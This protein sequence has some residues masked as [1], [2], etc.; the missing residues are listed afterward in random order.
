MHLRVPPS[1]KP[2]LARRALLLASSA[3]AL[4]WVAGCGQRQPAP[5]VSF[6]LLNGRPGRIADLRGQVVL[7]NFWATSCAVCVAEMPLLAATQR[8]YQARGLHTL[9]VAMRHDP[10]AA[11]ALFAESRALPFGVV[12]DNTGAV[13]RSFGDVRVTPT[14]VLLD[15][16]GQIAQ[17]WEGAPEPAT[18]QARIE[19]LLAET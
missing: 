8:Q 15:R 7:V 16:R 4:G 3:T 13:A 9:A 18:L 5:D 11:V 12:I 19:R 17:R 1:E 10:P 14:S 6:T 2:D